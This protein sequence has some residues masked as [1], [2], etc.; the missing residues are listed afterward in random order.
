MGTI[1]E[2]A[3][4]EAHAQVDALYH[5]LG[6]SAEGMANEVWAKAYLNELMKLTNEKRNK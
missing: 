5:S 1:C 3:A 2:Q 6:S 4:E